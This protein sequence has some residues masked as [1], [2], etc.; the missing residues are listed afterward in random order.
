[1]LDIVDYKE[2]NYVR[3]IEL[4]TKRLL[5]LRAD[6]TLLAAVKVYYKTHIA[7]FIND[8]GMTFNPKNVERGLPA[9]VPFIL[10]P[11]QREWVD[12]VIEHW[13]TRTPGLSEKTRQMG[14]SWLMMATGCSLCLFND[15]MVVGVGSRKQEYIDIIGDPKSLIQKGRMF[16]SSLPKEFRG[17]WSA[18]QHAPHMRIMFPNTG[19]VLAGEAGDNIGRGNTTSLYFVDES[20]Y[21]EHPTMVDASLSQ[22]TNCRIDV[23][24]PNGLGNS[25]AQKRFGGNIDIF[26]YH[27][28]DDPTKDDEWYQKQCKELDPVTVASE[29]D[30]NYSASIEG[31]MIPGA[32]VQA[33]FDAH[34]KLGI[35]P[36]GN[37]IGSLDVADEGRDLNAFCGA[38]GIVIEHL[39]EWSGVGDD[40]YGTVLRAFSICD[41]RDYDT[42]RFD[43]DGLGAGVRGD[44]RVINGLRDRK[45]GVFGFRGSES[46][47]RPDEEDVRGRKN[48]DMFANMAA[49]SWWSLRMR[50]QKTHRW[51]VEGVACN[52]DE[53]ISIPSNIPLALK[54]MGELS[55]A[56]Y[57]FNQVGKMVVNKAPE[58]SKSPNLAD[59]VRIRYAPMATPMK[60]NPLAIRAAM[61]G[62]R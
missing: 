37:R 48:K 31:V 38:Y 27:W 62:V 56:T 29:L 53:I 14:L 51:I 34:H 28:R 55:Q 58:G 57:A 3:C 6:P 7:D 10:Y 43:Q 13:L 47:F 54:L 61:A 33:A 39:E 8:W 49:Q 19:A 16:L 60:I 20:A 24:T 44:A 18:K 11:K 30:I 50:F 5:K 12:W 17:G 45:L 26:T 40:I 23:S 52:K 2:P 22:T 4:R 59:A 36:T 1:M 32:W 35:K 46:P 21:L 42:L 9:N 15:G 41:Q 25:F